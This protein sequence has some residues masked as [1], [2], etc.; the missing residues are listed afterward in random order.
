MTAM[1]NTPHALLA[2]LFISGLLAATQGVSYVPD[3]G[4]D[5]QCEYKF[6]VKTPVDCSVSDPGLKEDVLLMKQNIDMTRISQVS[7]NSAV[8]VLFQNEY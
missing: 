1:E 2:A 7:S 3:T 5:D 4:A 8:Q 6:T